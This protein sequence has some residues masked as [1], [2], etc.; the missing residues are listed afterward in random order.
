VIAAQPFSRL[1]VGL[2]FWPMKILEPLLCLHPWWNW[3]M[4]W[5][6][7][8]ADHPL[9]LSVIMR[10]DEKTYRQI[11]PEATTNQPPSILRE[12]KWG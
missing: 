9:L 1:T 5:L 3:V 7:M 2:E 12:L 10:R 4:M 11:W 6:M 8:G